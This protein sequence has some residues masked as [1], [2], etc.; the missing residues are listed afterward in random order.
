MSIVFGHNHFLSKKVSPH[1]IGLHQPELKGMF[2]ER[3]QRYAHLYWIPVFPIG[4]NWYLRK[5]GELHHVTDDVNRKLKSQFSSFVDWKA[6]ALPLLGILGFGIFTI[7][8]SIKSRQYAAQAI[9][10]NTQ[11][12]DLVKSKFNKVDNYS[13][14]EFN[15]NYESIYYKVKSRT[16][17]SV[18][19]ING[20]KN[21][22]RDGVTVSVSVMP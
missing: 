18:L 21:G 2:F 9:V 11:Q 6:F 22:D 15:K 8:D 19:Q 5:N 4:Q 12:M 16:G 13:C 3:R 20:V 17:V 14:L 7:S 1:E 10:S